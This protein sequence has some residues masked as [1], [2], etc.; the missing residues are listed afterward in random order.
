MSNTIIGREEELEVLK[1]ALDSEKAEF[2]AVYGRRRVGKTY[3]IRSFFSNQD[4]VFFQV[5]GIQHAKSAEQLIEFKKEI[6]NVF[7]KSFKGTTLSNPKNWLSA[8]EMLDDAIS[9]FAKDKKVVLFFDEFPWMAKRK[10]KLL[11]A[12]DYYWNRYWSS[13]KNI[14][15]VICGSAASWIIENILNNKGGLHNRVTKRLPIESFTLKE[16]KEYLRNNQINYD[17]YQV[18]QL[19]MCLGGI[20]YY[21]DM[22]KKGLSAVQN[23][24]ELCF[25]KRGTLLDEFHNLFSA[26]FE[27][28]TIH[29]NII[30]FISTKREGVSREEIEKYL[31][32]KGGRLTLWLKELEQAEFISSFTPWG[33]KYGAYYKITDEYTFFYLSWIEPFIKAGMRSKKSSYWEEVAQ[34]PAYKAWAGYAFEA[35]CF[36]HISNIRNALH[37]SGGALASTWRYIPPKN[38][39]LTGAQIDLLFDRNDNIVNICEI[40]HANGPYKIDKNYASNLEN[41]CKI[42]QEVT[43]THKQVVISMITTF[44]L[45][46]SDYA[47]DIIFSGCDLNDLFKDDD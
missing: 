46:K 25:R 44:G 27:H 2:L 32:T 36:K 13:N 6:Q 26:L 43:K 5:S 23:I 28:G 15:L 22:L 31:G 33:R 9:V 17:N 29:E 7:Y 10:D 45:Q 8:F 18:L 40:K 37:I 12:L 42:Y 16:V 20:P 14:K 39:K 21:L 3:L 34:M 35:V 11:Q 47:N 19:Y 30:K 1:E 38:S 4:C 41:K 24:N